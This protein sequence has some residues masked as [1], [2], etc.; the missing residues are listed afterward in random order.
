M[1]TPFLFLPLL[2]F[3]SLITACSV[4]KAESPEEVPA[5]PAGKDRNMFD[6]VFPVD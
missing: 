1:K 3:I 2:L 5:A 4:D 6:I